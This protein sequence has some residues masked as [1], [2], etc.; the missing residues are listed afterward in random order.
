MMSAKEGTTMTRILSIAVVLA[1][2]GGLARW[3]LAAW[4]H[5][6]RIGTSFVNS[7]V[8]PLLIRRGLAGGRASEIGTL[9]HIGRRTGVRRLTLVHPEP[10]ADGFRIMVPLGEQS[11]W[12]RNVLAAGQCRLQVHDLVYE[13]DEP[14]MIAA[15][16]V[17]DLPVAVR[18]LA[19]WLGFEYLTLHSFGV[20]PATLPLIGAEETMA[21]Q[22][23]SEP[24]SAPAARR[25]AVATAS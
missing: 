1:A 13:L 7:V 21:R 23:D 8:N 22:P 9:E 10:T 5:N 3:A 11:Q 17:D 4:R 19:G 20:A 12:A 15:S 6:R 18:R 24:A 25:E 14:A 16:Q 2:I